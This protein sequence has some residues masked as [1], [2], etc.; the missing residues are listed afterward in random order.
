MAPCDDALRRTHHHLCGILIEYT[1]CICNH[2]EKEK[3]YDEHS[4]N[5]KR[6]TVLKKKPTNKGH[7]NVS[8]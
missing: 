2:K 4:S 8:D 3:K 7:G 6:K 5:Q 1:T